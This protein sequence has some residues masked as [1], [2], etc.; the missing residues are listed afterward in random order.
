MFSAAIQMS[1]N[2]LSVSASLI[3]LTPPEFMLFVSC[4]TS[5]YSLLDEL[6]CPLYL[7]VRVW[8]TSDLFL[9]H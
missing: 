7:H 9:H 8:R 5:F 1:I 6:V 3:P 4:V 2:I